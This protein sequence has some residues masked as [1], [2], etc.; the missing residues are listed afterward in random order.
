M[1][2]IDE[3]VINPLRIP[4][5]LNVLVQDLRPIE[6]TNLYKMHHH[7]AVLLLASDQKLTTYLF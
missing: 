1:I 7:M 3:I 4:Q 5:A 2:V 6:K